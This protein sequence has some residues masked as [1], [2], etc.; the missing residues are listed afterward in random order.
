MLLGVA[1]GVTVILEL[2]FVRNERELDTRKCVSEQNSQ[3][4][5][6]AN[7]IR[8]QREQGTLGPSRASLTLGSLLF[9]LAG[10]Q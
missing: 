5:P 7:G 9:R 2:Y 6:A 8:S 4:C 3:M 10:L 1:D